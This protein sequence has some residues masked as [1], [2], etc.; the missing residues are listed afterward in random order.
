FRFEDEKEEAP[1]HFNFFPDHLY[2]ELIIGLFLMILL[3]ALAT[4]LPAHM[5]APADPQTTPEVIKPEW[6]FYVTFRWLKLFAGTTAVLSMGFIVFTIFAWP[7]IDDLIR[8]KT[9]FKEASVW[10]G[11]VGALTIITMTV[12]EAVVKH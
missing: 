7:F 11:I 12:W 5:G 6:F 4:I 9:R 3:S 10:I 1:R 8:R 2:T